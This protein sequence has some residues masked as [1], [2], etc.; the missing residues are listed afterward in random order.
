MAWPS[1]ESW[2]LTVGCEPVP[3]GEHAIRPAVGGRRLLGVAGDA[4]LGVAGEDERLVAG[5][6]L[7]GAPDVAARLAVPLHGGEGHHRARPLVTGGRAAG[8]AP[9]AQAAGGEHRLLGAPL[10]RQGADLA[11]R[12]AALALRPLRRLG[13]VVA[14]AEHVVL[15]LVEADGVLA[16]V[17]LVV[18]ILGK[19]GVGD[20]ETEGHV[21]AEARREPLVAEE[22]GRVIE[23]GVDEHH[24]E[25]ELFHPVA[26]AGA[27][28][29]GVDAAAGRLGVGRP[30]DDHLAVLERVL[31]QV[32]L[33]GDAEA[34]AV[35]PHRYGTPVPSLPAV[36][37]VGAL[38]ETH[39][40]EEA[41]VGAVP[42]ADVAPEVMRAL[43]GHD[44]AGA[45]LTMAALDLVGDD[46]ERSLPADGL[47]ARDP[48]VADVARALVVEVDA[49]ERRE[50]A[51]GR[52]DHG[53]LRLRVRR[54]GGAARRREA[55]TPR[56]DDPVALVV[57]VK[58]DREHADD[59]PVLHVDEERSPCRAVGQSY[60][61][62]HTPPTSALDSTARPKGSY[63]M[64]AAIG[65]IADT[66]ARTSERLQGGEPV[67]SAALPR[68]AG[69]TMIDGRPAEEHGA[70]DRLDRP[71]ALAD[72]LDLV[73]QALRPTALATDAGPYH[74]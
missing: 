30:E 40:V 2:V 69:M 6:A 22:L 67:S 33:L 34:V 63:C 9:A 35:A 58:V 25:A 66:R 5:R 51:L 52:V 26:A 73:L 24:L 42:V 43:G 44:G 16:H 65:R 7:R 28:E 4:A 29:G 38:G 61:V 32:P 15:P 48:A 72:S 71:R 59:A 31:E 20:A 23:V 56:L 47:V 39:E 10:A 8:A 74:G 54:Q 50:D 55:A 12:D 14:L 53:T 62:P 70:R 41:V 13:H 11:R 27:L 18:E 57:V 19:P 49:L 64:N 45:D 21:G 37:V 60:D 1:V 3:V 68:P 36:G 46:V 17:V